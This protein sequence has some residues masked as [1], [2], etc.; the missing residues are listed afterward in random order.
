MYWSL[1]SQLHD[2]RFRERFQL[3][4]EEYL[5]SCDKEH[6]FELEKQSTV[7]DELLKIATTISNQPKNT[8]P[9]DLTNVLKKLLKNL[10][11]PSTFSTPLDIKIQCSGIIIDDCKVM[12]SK[13]R[14]LKL[15]FQNSDPQGDPLVIFFKAGDD[16]RQD[17]LTLQMLRIMDSLWKKHGYDFHINPYGCVST[18]KNV[19]MIHCVSNSITIASLSSDISEATAKETILNWI[20]KT[21]KTEE[22]LATAVDNFKLSCAG[23]LVAT[24][25]LGIGDRHNDNS[26]TV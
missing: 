17:E 21:G 10:K 13:K 19:G 24:H 2:L 26:I 4:I 25:V 22:F 7:I 14:P 18:S 9:Q 8:K 16:L 3:I 6:K 20:K 23:Y 5:R 12:K 15:S 1:K 11:L